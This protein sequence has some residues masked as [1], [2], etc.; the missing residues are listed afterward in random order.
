MLPCLITPAFIIIEN[1][2]YR[3]NMQKKNMKLFIS[4][5]L[6]I[7]NLTLA[8]FPLYA[9]IQFA[10]FFETSK[11]A[12][13]ETIHAWAA[14]S[15]ITAIFIY[16][17]LFYLYNN[18]GNPWRHLKSS[19]N[20]QDDRIEERKNFPP[21]DD[22]VESIPMTAPLKYEIDPRGQDPIDPRS[23]MIK[24]KKEIDKKIKS[25]NNDVA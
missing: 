17:A 12:H 10:E 16:A 14:V 18:H 19:Q 23:F 24:N 22:D 8:Y 25:R 5:C 11:S 13:P 1:V 2:N 6:H 3:P 15:Y 4:F 21:Q 20:L 7:L 9:V